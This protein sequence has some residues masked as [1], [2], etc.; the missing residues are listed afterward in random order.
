MVGLVVD[1]VEGAV[2]DHSMNRCYQN[3]ARYL[4]DLEKVDF[5]E[6]V[7]HHLLDKLAIIY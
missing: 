2:G 5:K 6:M 4:W 1:L 7:V 3:Q